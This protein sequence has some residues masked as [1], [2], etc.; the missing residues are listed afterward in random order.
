EKEGLVLSGKNGR[1]TVE[2]DGCIYICRSG[3]RVRKNEGKILAGDRVIFRDNGDGNGFIVAMCNRKNSLIRPPVANIDMLAMVVAPK[4]P[5]PYLYNID[6]L[7]VIAEKNGIECAIIISKS[8]LADCAE[9]L[10]IYKKTP[11]KVLTTSSEAGIGIEEARELLKNKIC[12]LC[13]A[14]GVGKST[15]LNALYPELELETGEL[16]EKI[17][18]GKNTTRTTELFPLQN[19]TYLADTP[20]FTAVNTELYCAIDH[21]ELHT[22]FPE[23]EQYEHECRYADCTHTKE[24]E[25][26]IYEAV[27]RGEIARSRHESYTKLYGELKSI[28]RY[29]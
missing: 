4:D 11:F 6:L 16:S 23:F 9:I 5:A 15:L 8:D 14:S 28:D 21:K 3:T 29:K 7:T 26:G 20:G 22:L 2:A 1:Y 17:A 18:R 12:V 27:Q 25:C 19:G 10:E 13:G 24:T